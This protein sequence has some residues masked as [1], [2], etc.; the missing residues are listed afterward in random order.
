M[1]CNRLINNLLHTKYDRLLALLLRNLSVFNS[2]VYSYF[3]IK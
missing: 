3:F 2:Y 1:L